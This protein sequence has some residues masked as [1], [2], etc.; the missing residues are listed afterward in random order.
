VVAGKPGKNPPFINGVFWIQ[1]YVTIFNM[2]HIYKNVSTCP[3]FEVL[4]MR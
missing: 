3:H 1:G 4:S 2:M